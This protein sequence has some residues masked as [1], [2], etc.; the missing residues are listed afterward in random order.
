M[1]SNGKVRVSMQITVISGN[2][3]LDNWVLKFLEN[4]AH[5]SYPK[6]NIAH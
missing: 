3:F 2:K 1:T 5:L 6:W 4:L